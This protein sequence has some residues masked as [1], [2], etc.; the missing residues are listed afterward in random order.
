MRIR[1]HNSLTDGSTPTTHQVLP[2]RLI[3]ALYYKY[4][5]EGPIFELTIQELKYLLGLEK[6]RDNRRIYKAIAALQH[7]IQIRD[8]RYGEREVAWFSAP[9]LARAIRYKNK[10][11]I[12]FTIDPLI[13]EALH[14]KAGYTPLDLDV[15]NSFKSKYGLKLYEL[16][17]RYYD[18]PHKEREVDSKEVG[19]IKRRLR[20][21]N[22]LFG[23]NFKYPSQMAR[24]IERGAQEVLKVTGVRIHSFYNRQEELFILTWERRKVDT[25]DNLDNLDD[26]SVIPINQIEPFIEWYRSNVID[27]SIEYDG[28]YKEKLRRRILDGKFFNL[29]EFYRFYL[30]EMGYDPDACFDWEKGKFT[31]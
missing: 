28:A 29:I 27:E 21:L 15:C 10:N 7:P 11:Q 14:Q 4:E 18:L 22:A 25:R 13:I 19:V 3:N 8:F 26:Q 17:K 30:Q 20:E 31:C 24:A 5:R 23:S 2:D 9:F 1:K 16:Y 6:E 12:E